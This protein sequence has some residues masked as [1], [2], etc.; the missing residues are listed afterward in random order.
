MRQELA[1]RIE[2]PDQTG[3]YDIVLGATWDKKDWPFVNKSFTYFNKK[4][5]EIQELG[6]AVRALHNNPVLQKKFKEKLNAVRNE[7]IPHIYH[8]DD[9]I[10]RKFQDQSFADNE[11]EPIQGEI[12]FDLVT[13]RGLQ[14][15]VDNFMLLDV[16]QIKSLA[17]GTGG[18]TPFGGDAAL[19]AQN[20][21][22]SLEVEGFAIAYGTEAR[23]GSP[24]PA[25]LA[26][27]NVKEV[28]LKTA[29]GATFDLY[30][31]SVFPSSKVIAHANLQDIYS[32]QHISFFKST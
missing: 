9:L 25:T 27:A 22:V 20:A 17:T 28:G 8:F 23:H 24:F 32:I 31:R 3:I 2:L 15:I 19:Q 7:V 13:V 1:Q 21:E 26:T 16:A 4:S 5:R 30:S 14:M 18:S 29:L 6:K 11:A 12:G 10:I